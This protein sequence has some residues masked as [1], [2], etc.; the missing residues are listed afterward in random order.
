MVT[1]KETIGAQ[2]LEKQSIIIEESTDKQYKDSIMVDFFWEKCGL[3]QQ[4]KTG[5]IVKV[6]FNPRAKEYNNRR[7]NGINGWKIDIIDGSTQATKPA[8]Q[9]AAP[10]DDNEDLPF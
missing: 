7:Y 8:A 2:W 4:I 1:G 6:L 10:Y 9:Q 3:L 5:N